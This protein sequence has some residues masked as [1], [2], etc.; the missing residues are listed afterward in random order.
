MTQGPRSAAAALYPNLKTGMLEPVSQRAEPRSVADA[1]YPHLRPA[2][3]QAH[4][5]PAR[6]PR[7]IREQAFDW[8][9]VDPRFARMVGLVRKQP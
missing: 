1:I 2:P 7:L 6:Q 8:S 5:H 3:P 4:P 9:D